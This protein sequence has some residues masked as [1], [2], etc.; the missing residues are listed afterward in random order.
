[1]LKNIVHY[2]DILTYQNDIVQLNHIAQYEQ[3][4]HI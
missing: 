4:V 1:M 2:E 3:Y